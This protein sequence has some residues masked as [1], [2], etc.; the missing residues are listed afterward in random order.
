M[1]VLPENV[2]SGVWVFSIYIFTN[3]NIY[4]LDYK[5]GFQEDPSLSA[6]PKAQICMIL[7]CLYS[8]TCFD[9]FV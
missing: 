2:C 6:C 8:I 7:Q 4:T 3:I 1:F 9:V 5:K